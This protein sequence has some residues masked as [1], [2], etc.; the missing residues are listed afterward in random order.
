MPYRLWKGTAS[1]YW[2]G[3]RLR[4]LVGI[5]LNKIYTSLKSAERSGV[6]RKLQT[7]IQD[8]IILYFR[9]EYVTIFWKKKYGIWLILNVAVGSIASFRFF[10]WR[11]FQILETHTFRAYNDDIHKGTTFCFW[12]SKANY[13]S[14]LQIF[15]FMQF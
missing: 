6:H 15:E 8:I 5:H 4:F 7:L 13:D 10:P 14:H 9:E 12:S 3:Y 11:R 1:G 2:H